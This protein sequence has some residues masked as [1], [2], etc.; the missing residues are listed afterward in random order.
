VYP[1]GAGERIRLAAGAITSYGSAE[2]FP[3]S[4]RLLV[5]GSESSRAPRCYEQGVSGSAPRP[6]TPEGV[7]ASLAPDGKTLLLT[8]PD[9][10]SRLS[11]TDGGASRPLTALR[12]GD[13]Q[14]AWSRDSQ[15]IYVQHGLDV[16]AVVERVD[17]SSGERTVAARLTPEG[18]G[19]IAMIYVI[20][21]VEDGRW[22]VYN[23]TSIP[24]TLFVVSN[25]TP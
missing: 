14:I 18:L 10:S 19:A 15:A 23:Y 9:G 13:R 20:D 6:L 4:A 8:M 22:Y 1:T 17:L 12:A 24:S 7:L 25:A 11:F 21:W 2:W 5:C 16:P 3:D